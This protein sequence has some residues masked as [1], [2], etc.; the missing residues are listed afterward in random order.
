MMIENLVF[1]KISEPQ[2][3]KTTGDFLLLYKPPCMHSVPGK[4]ESIVD[5]CLCNYPELCKIKGRREGECGLLQRLDYR[6]HGLLLLARNHN[7][8]SAENGNNGRSVKR[9]HERLSVVNTG[10]T[11]TSCA[12][13]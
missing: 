11:L 9:F 2:V 6:T 3:L 4:G 1:N 8:C 10:K 12:I 13:R 5:R 7:G